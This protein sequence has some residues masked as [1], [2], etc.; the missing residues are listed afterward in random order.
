MLR[1]VVALDRLHTEADAANPRAKVN[2][3]KSDMEK[4]QL[5]TQ[6]TSLIEQANATGARLLAAGFASPAKKKNAT[7][8]D[9]T[10]VVGPVVAQ[11][12][13][14]WFSSD[15]GSET[16]RRMSA[17]GIS[18]RG[19]DSAAGDSPFSGKTFVLT[20]T[21]Q[22]MSRGEAQEKI[23]AQGGNVSSSV[24]S[25][26]HFVVAGPGAGSKLEDAQ[27]H[28]VTV[29]S[30][31]EFVAMLGGAKTEESPKQDELF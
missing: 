31:E 10:T 14:A 16:L 13:L 19:G 30:E 3:D 25:K 6:H 21:L 29:I 5:A 27:K 2:R 4:L 1:D 28:G 22:T 24:S 9:V 18:P 15:L 7:D 12:A 20:G 17:L 23:R 26:T 8:A 11:A